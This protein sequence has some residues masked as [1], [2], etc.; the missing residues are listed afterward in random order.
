[1]MRY[2]LRWGWIL[3]IAVIA[4]ACAAQMSTN[5]NAPATTNR[6]QL[7]SFTSTDVL[8]KKSSNDAVCP[9]YLQEFAQNR[10]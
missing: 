7:L 3:V 5:M 9:D 8:G 1:M 10:A 6:V 4:A 2:M